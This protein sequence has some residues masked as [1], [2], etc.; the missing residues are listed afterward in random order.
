MIEVGAPDVVDSAVAALGS[1][2]DD[3]ALLAVLDVACDRLVTEDLVHRL[4]PHAGR[5]RTVDYADHPRAALVAGVA[6]CAVD[7]PAGRA[8]LTAGRMALAAAGDVVGEGYGCFL[9][10][11]EDLG[12]GRLASAVVWWDRSRDLLGADHPIEGFNLAN[13]SLGA[14][15]GGDLRGAVAMAERALATAQLSGSPRHEGIAGI[16]VSFFNVWTG[17]FE[18]AGLAARH[19]CEAIALL[20]E[21]DRYDLPLAWGQVGAVAAVRNQHDHSM[22]AFETGLAVAASFAN[23]WHEAILRAGRADLLETLDPL[24]ALAD[25]RRARSYFERIGEQWWANWARQAVAATH[26]RLGDLAAADEACRVLR[27]QDLNPLERGR[28]LTIH[29][30]VAARQG[31]AATATA[32][33]G[34]AVG[35]LDRAGADFWAARAEVLAAGVDRRRATFHVRSAERRADGRRDGPAWHRMLAGPGALRVDV[36]GGVRVTVD[37]RTVTFSTHAEEEALAMLVAAW[38]GGVRAELI[39]DRLWPHADGERAAHRCDNLL[40]SLRG[41]L[42]PTTRIRRAKGLVSIDLQPEESDLL[43]IRHGLEPVT[44]ATP[45]FL[46]DA[47]PEWVLDLQIDLQLRHR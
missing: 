39:A 29:G 23:E 4:V 35:L 42:L 30:G 44:A 18:R 2:V 10:G 47:A 45:P 15:Q 27:E 22:A 21:P 17:D 37:G 14:Y 38:P 31:D 28:A 20:P 7:R 6:I 5:L 13:R 46:G 40:S 1:G 34:E 19:A 8:T 25:A 26:L 43:R 32:R 33:L 36:L 12:E 9:E 24:D 41:A 11:L 16:Y 3:D